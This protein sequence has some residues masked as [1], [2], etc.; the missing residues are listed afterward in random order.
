MSFIPDDIKIRT[1]DDIKSYLDDLQERNI[2]TKEKLLAWLKDC[3]E[4]ME[5][6]EEDLAWRYINT[7]RY[8]NN[9]SYKKA[10][11]NFIQNILPKIEQYENTLNKKFIE[12]PAVK[13]LDY[14]PY[15]ILIR[16]I[17]KQIELFR[18][19]NILLQAEMRQMEQEYGNIV[20]ELT[21]NYENKELTLQQAANYL[22]DTDR[23]IRE[24]IFCKINDQRLSVKDR[25]ND[26]YSKLIKIRTKIAHNSG[27]DNYRDYKFD[28]M[29]RFDYTVK[30]CETFHESVRREV[31][32]LVADMLHNR[33]YKLKI[34]ELKPW[35]LDVD[36]SGKSSLKPYDNIDEFIE[37]TIM[38]F[39]N[40][41]CDFGQ[42]METMSTM[43]H[44]D[45]ESRKNKAPGGFNYP[46]Y[47]TGVPFIFGN[48]TNSFHDLQ[49][50]MHE[51]G[52]AVHSFLT[53]KL[54]L[55]YFKEFPSEVA[56]LASMSMELISMRHWDLFFSNQ[57]DLR[58]AKRKQLQSVINVLPWIMTIDKFQHWI[59]TH[60]EHT[61]EE[62]EK[63]WVEIY[64][65]F[66]PE[67]ISWKGLEDYK[68]IIWQKQLH[69]FEVPF[70]YIE[71]A[72][73][74]LGAIAIWKNF[75]EE[76]HQAIAN[77]L[78][79]MSLGYTKNIPEIYKTAG[80]E[81]NFSSKY[82]HGLM[83][84]VKEQMALL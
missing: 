71:Y 66:H 43:K 14:D 72:F 44:L 60:P 16:H 77:Y 54:P 32:P 6:V 39:R 38:C 30:D 69:L 2:S 47:K 33:R 20:S 74:Q 58:R 62:R 29:G 46:L 28:E 51:G 27:Y 57:M 40:I 15:Y 10:Y 52:H 31:L 41:D 81:F 50:I 63:K 78:R 4:L 82:I 17:K 84:F 18:E 7:N 13:E 59:Y 22:Y 61:V 24:E 25:L 21:I 23:G 5:T 68:N 3:S 65:T 56:E 26:L 11:S 37:N 83:D 8:T 55:I 53:R 76:T 35:D 49:T 48:F 1:L 12:S 79:G 36:T 67:I 70:Y 64:E 80:I 75:T 19:E 42:F 9:T 45:L 34:S 73:S